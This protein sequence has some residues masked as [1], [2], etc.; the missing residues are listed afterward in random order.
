MPRGRK[1]SKKEPQPGTEP[2]LYTV[3]DVCRI[4]ACGPTTV[5]NLADANR[6][7]KVKLGT[8]CVRYTRES[9]M[10]CLNN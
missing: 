3:R 6:L 5:R 4:L 7:T 8:R 10:A 9:V 2:R 1:P